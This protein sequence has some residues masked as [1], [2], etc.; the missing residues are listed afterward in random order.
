MKLGLGFDFLK[1]TSLEISVMVP[2][3]RKTYFMSQKQRHAIQ[4]FHTY[5]WNG[6]TWNFYFYLC[7]FLIFVRFT[8][9]CVNF[10]CTNTF[11]SFLSG[12]I[13]WPVIDLKQFRKNQQGCDNFEVRIFPIFS[14]T[15]AWHKTP[16]LWNQTEN[17]STQTTT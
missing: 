16:I 15:T 14:V 3:S 4:D 6:A 8:V 10:T 11:I 1:S 7:F 9:I 5:L 12:K 2:K 13:H 17:S